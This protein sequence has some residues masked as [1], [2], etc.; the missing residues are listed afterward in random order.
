MLVR[1]AAAGEGS[2]A[3]RAILD[4]ALQTNPEDAG[5]NA[6]QGAVPTGRP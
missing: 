1:L 3:A 6:L 2:A 5:L 4:E